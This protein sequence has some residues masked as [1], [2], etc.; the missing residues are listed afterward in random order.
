MAYRSK[1]ALKITTTLKLILSFIPHPS[2]FENDVEN[3]LIL[4]VG[5]LGLERSFYV[6]HWCLHKLLILEKRAQKLR[7]IIFVR[8][9]S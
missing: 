7:S 2:C 3:L 5:K 9:F 4:K 1:N 6:T 8:A